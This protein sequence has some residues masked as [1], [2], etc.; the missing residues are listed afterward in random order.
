MNTIVFVKKGI[1]DF[2]RRQKIADDHVLDLIE[3]QRRDTLH[4][5]PEQKAV[6]DAA[7]I[8]LIRDGILRKESGYIVLTRQGFASI[9]CCSNSESG[10]EV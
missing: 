10:L 3:F 6:L 1:I 4:W 5:T 7:L 2:F 9:Y 8:E